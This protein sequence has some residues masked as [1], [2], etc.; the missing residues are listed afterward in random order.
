[1]SQYDVVTLGE[2]MMRLSPPGL[3]RIEQ[4]N[5]FEIEIG[6]TESNMAVAM[7]RL[8]LKVAWISRL[9]TNALG[10]RL[11]RILSANE[12]DVSHVVWA[13]NERLG[14]FFIEF[15]EGSRPTSL[16]YDRADS[17]MA[18]MQPT[19]LPADLFQ[20]GKARHLHLTGITLAI[21]DKAAATAERA[22]RLAKEA[23]WTVSFD[24]NYRAKLWT[25]EAC[26]E[27]CQL[28]AEA[29]DLFFIPLR[30]AQTI[31]GIP[32]NATPEEALATFQAML[33]NATIVVTLGS[34]G[35][36][37]A[38]P[39]KAPIQQPVF[40]VGGATVGRIGAGDAFI[41]GVL[42]RYLAAE[43]RDQWL[44]EGLLWGTA[45]AAF[46]YT[47]PGDMALF[48]RDEIEA[49]IRSAGSGASNVQR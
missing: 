31:Y 16:I 40:P 46:K 26:R 21:S 11:S 37:A 41:A 39:G 3:L 47:I 44:S 5:V 4:T 28:Y 27:G 12:V 48:E 25:P 34:G 45:A 19:D 8:G 23:G 49:L 32:E 17:A 14:T 38:E 2:T 18:R 43:D 10:R 24:P 6:G 33:P 22:L 13:D 29:A 15:G 7:S 36:L 35:A 9:P 20:P 1:M 30:D 42:Y